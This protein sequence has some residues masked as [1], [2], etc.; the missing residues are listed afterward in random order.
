L[1]FSGKF[2]LD[3]YNQRW[4]QLSSAGQLG[5][6]ATPSLGLA[7]V[8]AQGGTTNA[9]GAGLAGLTTPSYSLEDILKNRG[10][11]YNSNYWMNP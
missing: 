3:A 1:D 6:G 5:L 10:T 8:Q 4:N 9:L 7:N 2:G 11:G